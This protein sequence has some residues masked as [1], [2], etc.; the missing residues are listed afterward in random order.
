MEADAAQLSQLGGD[1]PRNPSHRGVVE[2]D[3]HHVEKP[4][5]VPIDQHEEQVVCHTLKV[6]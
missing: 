3:G 1:A 4:R 6:A 5:R 2:E